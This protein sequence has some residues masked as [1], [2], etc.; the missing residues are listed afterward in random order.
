MAT[1]AN[2]K[3]LKG[4]LATFVMLCAGNLHGQQVK[5][6]PLNNAITQ[7]ARSIEER[8]DAKTRVA[9]LD[10]SSDSE[11]VSDYIIDKLS[12][13]LVKDKVTVIE[14][15]RRDLIRKEIE[16]HESGDVDDDYMAR[17]GKQWGAQLIIY[18]SLKKLGATLH[19]MIKSVNVET[20]R[21][22]AQV[23]YNIDQTDPILAGN[24]DESD[25]PDL[26]FDT[27]S[28]F[29]ERDLIGGNSPAIEEIPSKPQQLTARNIGDF[30]VGGW[31]SFYNPS[32]ANDGDLSI[33]IDSFIFF[34]RAFTDSFRLSI[35]LQHYSGINTGDTAAYYNDR[36]ISPVRDFLYLRITP[37]LFLPL[38]PGE[39]GLSLQLMP[40]F[41]LTNNYDYF[42]QYG[43]H[44][45][46]PTF[47]FD[48]VI[49]YWLNI[50]YF[51]LG[52]DNMGIAEGADYDNNTREYQ[53][54]LW[55]S[56]LYFTV[57]AKPIDGLSLWVS[58]YFF[59]RTND[60]QIDSYFRKLRVG[61]SYIFTAQIISGLRVDFPI[62]TE[63]N[64][65]IMEYQGITL[66]PYVRARFGDLSVTANFYVYR[67][68][69][70]HPGYRE[71]A[72]M[73]EIG[74]FYN[75]QL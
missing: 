13:E 53:Y 3:I 54:G 20:A 71:V 63:V 39:L 28:L 2:K 62:G 23:S 27:S 50:F 19:F 30:Q 42:Y 61:M 15:Q 65:T 11:N 57:E 25:L 24:S 12:E 75:F 32:G 31:L 59:I 22:E 47:I 74:V 72:I 16:I 52:T 56:D 49:Q 37:S 33:G 66:I 38:G 14:R 60:Y 10:F 51:E 26:Q 68:G 69:V 73:P 45:I 8:L 67:V 48:P 40:V 58:P 36:G 64:K 17:I 1:M 4:M 41:Y 44:D 5:P 21:I 35:L 46:G 34:T 70:N 6:L 18:G 9:I 43:G 7:A 29:G 55:I